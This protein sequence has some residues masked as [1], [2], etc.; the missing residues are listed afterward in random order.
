MECPRAD[1]QHVVGAHHAVAGVHGAAFHQRQQVALYALPGDLRAVA[2]RAGAQLVKLVD[3]HDAIL[4][5]VVDGFGLDLFPVD[6]PGALLFGQL[7]QGVRYL[8]SARLSFAAPGESFQH[9]PQLSGEL[10]HA[11]GVP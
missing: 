7:A 6:A 5:E 10:L 4:F 2:F 3:K 9:V 8:Q 11:R 1:E